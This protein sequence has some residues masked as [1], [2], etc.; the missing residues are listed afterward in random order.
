MKPTEIPLGD[1]AF[2]SFAP[3]QMIRL[4]FHSDGEDNIAFMSLDAVGVLTAIKADMERPIRPNG[5]EK[6]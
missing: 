6:R 5:G 3:G 1:G 4:R 2:A